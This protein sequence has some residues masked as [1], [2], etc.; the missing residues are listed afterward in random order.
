MRLA[1]A[2]SGLR[3]KEDAMKV[4]LLLVTGVTGLVA[5]V[6]A[7]DVNMWMSIG[8]LVLL[9]LAVLAFGRCWHR[10][11]LALL[12]ATTDL[13]GD[14]LPPRWYCDQCGA[15]WPAVFERDQTPIQRFTGYDESKAVSAA[16][17][18]EHL[19]DRRRALALE[20][21]GLWSGA[22]TGSVHPTNRGGVV[23]IGPRRSVAR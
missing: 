20:R 11:P 7:S 4:V 1:L 15:E 6:L 16:R 22:P 14:M 3:S 5:V 19:Q 13:H 9:G 2:G 23:R 8:S 12:P 21:A 10:Q 18:A 17:R